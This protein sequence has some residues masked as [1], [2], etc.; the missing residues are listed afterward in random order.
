MKQLT[1]YQANGR[2]FG[3][4]IEWPR[5]GSGTYR[6]TRMLEIPQTPEAIE[7]FAAENGFLIEW[8][9]PF[10]TKPASTAAAKPD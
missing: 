2:W 10:P 3:S 4:E 1:V 7:A 6:Q 5:S 9:E 8:K